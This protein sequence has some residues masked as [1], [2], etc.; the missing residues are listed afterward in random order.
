MCPLFQTTMN[1][2]CLTTCCCSNQKSTYRLVYSREKI[3]CRAVDGSKYSTSSGRGGAGS[4][5][6]F[7]NSDKS[8]CTQKGT[9]PLV[10]SFWSHLSHNSWPLGAVVETF[11]D[12]R[13][14]VHRVKVLTK[15]A[16]YERPVDLHRVILLR[17]YNV[18]FQLLC[19]LRF[20]L[21]TFQLYIFA[22]CTLVFFVSHWV[23]PLFDWEF[24]IV[25]L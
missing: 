3:H 2:W 21:V 15:T 17:Q 4:T 14:F 11:P 8:G 13:G 6:P 7:C 12:K 10:I 5:F 16:V 1:P 25:F 20:A 9:W 19:S 22:F 23:K 24:E 18:S